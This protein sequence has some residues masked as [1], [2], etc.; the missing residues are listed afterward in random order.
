MFIGVKKGRA[1]SV[2]GDVDHPVNAGALCPKGL[3]EHE[4]M[5][6]ADRA[7]APLLRR[8]GR[9]RRAGWDEAI[10]AMVKAFRDTQARHGPDRVGVISTGQ[11]RTA[12]FYTL[13]Q[14]VQP[15]LGP[16]HYGGNP[17]CS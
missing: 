7:R 11:L 6:A 15:R 4:T 16:R 3:S 2:R 12:E 17:T 14:L 1:V 10:G 8:H 13:G 9:L 5:G